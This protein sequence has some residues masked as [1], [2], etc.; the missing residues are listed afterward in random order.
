MRVKVLSVAFPSDLIEQVDVSVYAINCFAINLMLGRR[1][2]MSSKALQISGWC[3]FRSG[4]A[5]GEGL[6]AAS[7]FVLIREEH[8]E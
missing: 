3:A 8:G 4:R 7:S 5:G 6:G 1:T 2:A